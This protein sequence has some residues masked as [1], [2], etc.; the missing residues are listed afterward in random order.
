MRARGSRDREDYLTDALSLLSGW[1]RDGREF[2]R[3]LPL[4]DSQHAALAERIKIVADALQLRPQVRRLDG[5][6]QIKLCTPDEGALSDGE[7]TLA[8]RIEAM[9]QT[10][11]QTA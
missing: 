4:D 6:T 10:I 9:Y 3:T 8:A 2:R 11:A 5:H 1:T 7:V